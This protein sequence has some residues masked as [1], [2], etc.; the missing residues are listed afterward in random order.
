MRIFLATIVLILATTP[1]KGQDV[2]QYLNPVIRGDVADPTIIHF[3]DHY[4]A[5]GTSSE[6]AP[7][8]P[9][10]ESED[11]INWRQVGHI[12]DKKPAWTSN[13][14]WA[15]ELFVHPEGH[16][17]CYYTAR[18]ADTGISYIGVASAKSPL[19]PFTDHGPI[20]EYG[21]EAIDAFV[22]QSAGQLYI[23]WKAYGL[24]NRPIEI[25]GS[26]L[27][28]DGLGLEGDPFIMLRDEDRIGMEGQYHFK[29][30]NFHYIIYAA[31][32]CC[33]PRS[34]YEVRVARSQKI[35]G[36][37]EKYEGNP[38]LHGGITFASCG[39]GTAVEVPDGR[40]FYMCHAYLDGE[41]FYLGR[42]PVLYEMTTNEAGWV[43]FVGGKQAQASRPVPFAGTVQQPLT[44]FYDDFKGSHL[45][46]DWTWNYPWSE[47]SAQTRGGKLVLGGVPH[48]GN[49]YG[50]ALCLRAQASNYI[51][52]TALA[53]RN[54][55]LQGLTMYGDARNLVVFGVQGNNMLIKVVDDGKETT[56]FEMA[57]EEKA[58]L[59]RLRIEVSAGSRLKFSYLITK[60]GKV[61]LWQT[62]PI[63]PLDRSTL[64]RWDRVARPGLIHI[65][66]ADQPARFTGFKMS[67]F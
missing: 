44:T 17:L 20:V 12:F 16:V 36:P 26:R 30:G 37:Y 32:G 13:S 27:T 9:I 3:D 19:H 56:L 47:V 11:L 18:Q 57:L 25:L 63:E 22:W 10:F 60:R 53:R 2:G 59:P 21:T 54:E 8:Y 51:Y 34:D 14:F 6:W 35:E 39:H 43:E 33:G 45:R 31:R 40:M 1:S 42:Q 64:V 61:G 28:A 49:R 38:I 29:R 66:E 62:V 52:E 4:Y 46:V 15:P 65:G 24:D 23:S 55:S 5:T 67:F 41:G 50:N 58:R 7:H 48:D